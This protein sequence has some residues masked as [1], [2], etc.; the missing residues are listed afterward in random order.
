MLYIIAVAAI[1]AGIVVAVIIDYAC[2]GTC[3]TQMIAAG[4]F[5]GT[6]VAFVGTSWHCWR[7]NRKSIA[8]KRM[9]ESSGMLE[10]CDK[11]TSFMCGVCGKGLAM[12]VPLEDDPVHA[13]H[14]SDGGSIPGHITISR[15]CFNAGKSVCSAK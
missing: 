15:V 7:E 10:I 6:V 5:V 8:S 3:G 4:L 14:V 9:K 1:V 2:M 13:D 12:E 11:C